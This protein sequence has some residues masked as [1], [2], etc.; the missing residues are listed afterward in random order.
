MTRNRTVIDKSW[1]FCKD[2]QEPCQA[3]CKSK[4]TL[5]LLVKEFLDLSITSPKLIA[6]ELFEKNCP[7][8]CRYRDFSSELALAKQSYSMPLNHLRLT[9]EMGDDSNSVGNLEKDLDYSLDMFISDVGNGFGFLLGL[10]LVSVIKIFLGSLMSFGQMISTM[11]KRQSQ[12][13]WIRPTIMTFKW[14]V[15]ACFLTYV[16]IGSLVR[17][18][19]DLMPF[20]L[21]SFSDSEAKS[22]SS[23]AMFFSSDKHSSNLKWGFS[24]DLNVNGSC[25]YES[26]IGDGFCDDK[27]NNNG[28]RFD[29]G[30]CCRPGAD[31]KP[32]GHWFCTDCKCHSGDDPN[33]LLKPGT[34]FIRKSFLW[35]SLKKLNTFF[36]LIG[37]CESCVFPFNHHNSH[38]PEGEKYQ[39]SYDCVF[40]PNFDHFYYCPTAVDSETLE[41]FGIPY[42]WPCPVEEHQLHPSCYESPN[43]G[44]FLG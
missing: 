43:N 5:E 21:T 32:N 40:I 34:D 12:L 18:F 37:L 1:Q 4:E 25:P 10:S 17:D 3:S 16:T 24:S 38:A 19:S 29:G 35:M 44:I 26:E 15:V 36:L 8:S 11:P 20:Q 28:C 9:F 42:L 33:M 14:T 39:R 30:D 41:P 27:A 22:E 31:R 13:Q 7:Y 6:K 2:A 23:A